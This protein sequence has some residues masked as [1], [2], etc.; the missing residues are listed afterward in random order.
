MLVYGPPHPNIGK[1]ILETA[2]NLVKSG[3]TVFLVDCNHRITPELLISIDDETLNRIFLI[4]P[5]TIKVASDI[6]DYLVFSYG[7][8]IEGLAIIFSSV[9]IQIPYHYWSIFNYDPL[10]ILYAIAEISKKARRFKGLVM[11][12]TNVS[13]ASSLPYHQRILDLFDKVYKIRVV[14][15]NIL[16]EPS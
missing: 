5:S 6:I 12:D 15:E 4:K 13:G 1:F 16:L 11:I 10:F 8:K 9:F 14:E 7:K 2:V 3:Y